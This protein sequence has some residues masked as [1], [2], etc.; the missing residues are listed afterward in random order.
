MDQEGIGEVSKLSC[1]LPLTRG[2]VQGAEK[3]PM[4]REMPPERG[5]A[6]REPG[7]AS[8]SVQDPGRPGAA[9]TG[10]LL[11][12][13]AGAGSWEM[14]CFFSAQALRVVVKVGNC[15]MIGKLKKTQ[16]LVYRLKSHLLVFSCRNFP[17]GSIQG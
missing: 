4:G 11:G 14:H 3:S 8:C 5:T 1:S 10:T 12:A 7:M 15:S 16:L 9:V 6:R 2:I 13:G 17:L